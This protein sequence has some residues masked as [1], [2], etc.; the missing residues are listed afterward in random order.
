LHAGLPALDGSHR[1]HH[2][3]GVAVRGIDGQHVHLARHQLQRALHEIAGG[4]DRRA[5]AQPA[6]AVLAA[7]GYFSF[8]WMSLT[9][10]R[11]LRL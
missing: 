8:F 1:G 4:A 11:P 10:I 7:F 3:R 9:V 2:A 6:L 5:H